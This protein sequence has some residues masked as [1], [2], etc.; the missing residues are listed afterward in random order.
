[1]AASSCPAQPL[2]I[3]TAFPGWLR[4]GASALRANMLVIAAERLTA[5]E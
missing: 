3:L 2:V 4:V 5:N 1:M